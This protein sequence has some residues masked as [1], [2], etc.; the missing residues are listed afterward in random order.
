M[1]NLLITGGFGF[2]GANFIKYILF[3]EGFK[4]NVINVD[5][6]TYAGNKE[7]LVEIEK[8]FPGQYLFICADIC[9]QAAMTEVFNVYEIDAV[10]H[11]AAESHVDRSILV[12][13]Y[14][15]RTNIFGTFNLLEL[16]R[17]HKNRIKIFHHI[18]TDEVFGSLGKKGFFTENTPYNPSSPYSASKAGSDHLVSSYWKT[19]DI[20]VTISN[21]SNNYGPYQFP[22]KLI[23]LAILNAL[24][25]KPVPIFVKGL[26]VRDWL[27]VHD[28]CRA[29]W[30]VI[31]KGKKG[32]TYN[33]GGK[34]EMHNIEVVRK[35]CDVL[36]ETQP[37]L[38]PER[39]F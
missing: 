12:P 36:D 13:Y 1:K 31:K 24:E 28:H 33:V 14:F 11:F 10:C 37:L 29:I 20:P 38:G 27:Y 35:I 18:S 30:S 22:E 25:G 34:C 23:P 6:L 16:C 5:K 7:N 3:D 15:I 21:C 26:N 8:L 19:Y 17:L 4:G 2:I 39:K 32:R 9:D